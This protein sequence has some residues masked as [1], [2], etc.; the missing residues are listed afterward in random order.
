M[1]NIG[2]RRE[3]PSRAAIALVVLGALGLS[4]SSP[5]EPGGPP[6]PEVPN[7]VHVA[8]SG[9]GWRAHTAQAG[10]TMSLLE[11]GTRTL[12]EVFKDVATISSNSGGTWFHSMLVYSGSFRAS[13][14]AADALPSY[15]TPAGYLGQERALF[16]KS[17]AAELHIDWCAPFEDSHPTIYF[18]CR[19]ATI[20]GGEGVIWSDIVTN[21]VFEPF[22]MKTELSRALLDGPRQTWAGGKS[23]LMAATMLTDHAVLTE[24]DW[25]DKLYYD[26]TVKAGPA[27]VSLTPLTFSSTPGMQA[28]PFLAAGGFDLLYAENAELDPPPPKKATIEN[29]L[30]SDH[31]PVLTA[32]AASSAALGAAASYTVLHDN[33]FGLASWQI[34]YELSDLA[35]PFALEPPIQSR[36]PAGT[37]EKLA[38]SKFVRIADGGYLDNSGVAQLVSFLQLN[39]QADDFHI[40]AFDNVQEV[41]QP[42]G[43]GTAVGTDIAYLFG[44][45]LGD[46]EQFCVGRAD[47][48]ICVTVPAQ[49]IFASGPLAE[50]KAVWS[51]LPEADTGLIYTAYEVTTV[52]NQTLGVK[53]GSSGTLRVFTC[54]W[55]AADTAPWNGAS[56]FDAY[57]AMLQAIHE[58]LTA[59][60]NQGLSYLRS[61]LTSGTTP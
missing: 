30:P 56:D 28:P 61:A 52:D 41:Y 42:S 9:G 54:A 23:L 14:E 25:L 36:P 8:F 22:G 34:A 1:R 46:G 19:L 47:D 43:D 37:V 48:K 49:Q 44:K 50:T 16:Q 33:D 31:V 57:E 13:I 2:F 15:A 5:E 32:T 45:G 7:P 53:A 17:E 21:V 60:G 29:P 4:C 51:Y 39:E 26:A 27:Q 24:N 20:A 58:G 35:L 59:N 40:V 18:Y 10:W 3:T 11:D 38:E 6:E 55:P 12:D